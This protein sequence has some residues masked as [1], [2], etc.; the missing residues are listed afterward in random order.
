ML[1]AQINRTPLTRRARAAA[2]VVFVA[3]TLAAIAMGQPAVAQIGIGSLSG[4][5]YDPSG[6]LLPGVAVGV[7]H[8]ESGR[9]SQVT[10]DRSGAFAL[11]DVPSGTYELTMSLAGFATVR[12]SLD[13]Q[14]GDI[15]QRSIILPLGT[16]EETITVTGPSDPGVAAAPPAPRPRTVR[17]QPQPRP[18]ASGAGGIG[19]NIRV[20]RMLVHTSPVFPPELGG[21][22][23]VV[24]VAGR[25]G[26]DGFLIDLKDVSDTRPHPAFV[27]SLM[28]AVRQW[29]YVPTL[30]NGAPVEANITIV[31]RFTSR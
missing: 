18:I 3:A 30:L 5:I 17:D 7:T 25:V 27:A 22:S 19:G 12:A 1:N 20:P 2:A 11:R 13:L 6:G 16:L 8:A 9:T 28:A 24:T 23:A 26:I 4:V 15:L 10:T 29:E 14:P 31:A 21:S